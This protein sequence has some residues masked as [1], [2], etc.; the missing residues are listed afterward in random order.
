MA[1]PLP[2]PPLD[3]LL[4]RARVV[5]LPLATRFRGVVE[6]EAVLFE[7]SAAHADGT[8]VWSEFSP[9]VEYRPAE[10]AAWL[11]AAIEYGFDPELERRLD[12]SVEVNATVPAVAADEVAGV[13]ARYDG[14]R[15]V[16]VKVAERGQSL[17]DD[18]SRLEAVRDALPDARLRIDANAGWSSPEAVTALRAIAA[19]GIELEYAEQPVAGVEGLAEV[20]RAVPG[21]R[22]AADEA[23]RKADDPLAVARAGA[24]DHVIVKAQPLGG[25]R[26]AA[27]VVAAS[28]L[29]ATVSSAL[30]TSVGIVMGA[31]LAARLPEPRYAAGLATV[32]LFAADVVREPRRP[33]AGRIALAP[34]VPDEALLREH[35]APAARRDWWLERIRDCWELLAR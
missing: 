32:S 8:P 29:T 33:V 23:V 19:A 14:C 10:A 2:L 7:G 9:F 1:A 13:L 6:R 5:A 27:E 4:E 26:R 16:K 31:Q 24:A 34:A 35:A 15:V 17:A 30:D 11:A 18:L 20:R 12:G 25:V 21:V 3:E 28:G 22:I